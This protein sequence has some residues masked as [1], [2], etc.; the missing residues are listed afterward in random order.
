MTEVTFH[1]Q[2]PDKWVYCCRLLRKA[3]LRD[4][5][6]WVCGDAQQIAHLD[7]L[8]WS[9]SP[10]DF[11]P[12]CLASA[13]SGLL[14]ASPVVLATDTLAAPHHGVLLNLG[15]AV[16]AGFESF[17]RVIEVVSTEGEDR[18][19]ARLRWKHYSERGYPLISH[20]A[21]GEKT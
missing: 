13:E 15:G 3:A 1:I 10:L 17:Q 11:V 19:Q 4:A 20:E 14:A 21:P 12:H 16:P 7:A 2:V 9:F 6:V 18:R 8:L 5:R